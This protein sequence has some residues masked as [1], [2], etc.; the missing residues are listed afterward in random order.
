MGIP[1]LLNPSRVLSS[2][3]WLLPLTTVMVSPFWPILRPLSERERSIPLEASCSEPSFLIN[4]GELSHPGSYS[5]RFSPALPTAKV[6]C[7]ARWSDEVRGN[8][9]AVR[10]D[11]PR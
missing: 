9:V 4:V 10:G 6:T 11:K 5:R 3:S 7:S 2:S 1:A 8:T